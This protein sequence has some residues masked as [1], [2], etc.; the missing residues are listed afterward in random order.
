MIS[1]MQRIR[2]DFLFSADLLQEILNEYSGLFDVIAEE[3]PGY[4]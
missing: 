4:R 3:D 1:I 2:Q